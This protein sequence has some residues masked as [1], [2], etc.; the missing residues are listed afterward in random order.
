[1]TFVEPS[2]RFALRWGSYNGR[3]AAGIGL[4]VSG[5]ICLQG[6]S[7]SISITMAL[8]SAAHALGWWLLPGSGRR[9]GWASVASLAVAWI[10][11]IGPSGLGLLAVNLAC[12]LWVRERSALSYLVVLP[13]LATGVIARSINAEYS[14][15]LPGLAATGA[16]L[17]AAAWTARLITTSRETSTAKHNTLA[18]R[19]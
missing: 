4:I 19:P 2:R 12:W 5:L 15:M 1:M 13:V 17:V 6:T 8:G 18:H 16:V 7:G 3:Y 14:G 9:R 11:L 10:L